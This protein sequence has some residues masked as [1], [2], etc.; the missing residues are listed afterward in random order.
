MP[1]PK[2]IPHL[3]GYTAAYNKQRDMIMIYVGSFYIEVDRVN[4]KWKSTWAFDEVGHGAASLF[5]NNQFHIFGGF[6]SPYHFIW[7]D[8]IKELEKIHTFNEYSEYICGAKAVHIAHKNIILLGGSHGMGDENSIHKYDLVKKKWEKLDVTLPHR[9]REFGAILSK[10][11]KKLVIFGGYKDMIHI[12]DIETMEWSESRIRCPCKST[13]QN[14]AINVC[15]NQK[16]N[17]LLVVAYIL[18]VYE[19]LIPND[20]IGMILEFYSYDYEEVHLFCNDNE[21]KLHHFKI[22]LDQILGP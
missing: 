11:E 18:D 6:D 1:V 21:C 10:N 3:H 8:N 13:K 7:N 20:L 16:R 2:D 15:D 19:K 22:V 9:M 4:N 14:W 12:L 5:I 17:E